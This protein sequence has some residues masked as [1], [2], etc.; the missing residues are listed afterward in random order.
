LNDGALK[1]IEGLDD[2]ESEDRPGMG[3]EDFFAGCSG[4]LELKAKI[5]AVTGDGRI[6]ARRTSM[7]NGTSINGR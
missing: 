2:V 4:P 5:G 1:P 3:V 7:S 6:V